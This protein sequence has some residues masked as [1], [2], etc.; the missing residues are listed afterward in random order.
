[1]PVEMIQ[2]AGER[3]LRQTRLAQ[4]FGEL[5]GVRGISKRQSTDVIQI[6]VS[7]IDLLELAPNLAG[8]LQA[9]QM[10]QSRREEGARQ[11]RIRSHGNALLEY[12]RRGLIVASHE[13]GGA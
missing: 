12:R 3:L 8:F 9:T 11:I 4:A 13:I 1:M 7:R 10:A 5:I 6:R 2:S